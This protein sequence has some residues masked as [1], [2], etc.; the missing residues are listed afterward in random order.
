LLSGIRYLIKTFV[1]DFNNLKLIIKQK[2]QT[3][4]INFVKTFVTYLGIFTLKGKYKKAIIT[5]QLAK[6]V[7]E[8]LQEA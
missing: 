4:L 5:Y 7:Y 2:R 6:E 1:A 8:G 3:Y